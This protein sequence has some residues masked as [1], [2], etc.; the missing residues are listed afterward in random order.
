MAKM[1]GCGMRRYVLLALCAASVMTLAGCKKSVSSDVAASVNGRPVKYPELDRII[2]AQFPNTPLKANDDQTTELHLETLRT[3]IDQEIML[4]RAEKEGLLASDGDVDAKYNELKAP[5]TQEEFQKLLA[6]RKM[7][8]EEFRAQ[9]RRELSVQK[10]FNKEIGSHISIS[11]A[12]VTAFY[13]ANKANYN[14]AE[15]RIRLAQILVT[16]TPD[17]DV[18]NL[19]NDKAQNDEQARNKIQMIEL[20]LR[21]GEDFAAIA[22]NYSEDPKYGPNGGDLGYIPESALDKTNPELRKAILNMIPGQVSPVLHTAEGY[23]ILKLLSREPAGQRELS[24]PRVQEDI[25]RT[26]FQR[27][28][29]LLRNAF[30]EVARDQAK[31]TNYYADSV[32]NSRDK[33]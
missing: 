12:E 14:L 2:A 9:V 16:P 15:N 17:P 3:L 31:V 23:R 8:S 25:R 20:R 32:L 10:L 22:Q 11:D 29:Q 7:S 33:K 19:K 30:Y 5:Y 28:D 21:Q 26:L 24:D 6:Q 1:K 18:H 13:N 4:Q 27:K